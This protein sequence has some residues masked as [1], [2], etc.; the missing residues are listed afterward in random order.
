MILIP[1]PASNEISSYMR[2]K[3][4]KTWIIIQVKP[5]AS[6]SCLETGISIVCLFVCFIFSTTEQNACPP[7]WLN[8]GESCFRIHI[9]SYET[10]KDAMFECHN[11]GGRLA[12]L[13][14]T[15]KLHALSR[16]IDEYMGALEYFFV[17]AYTTERWITVRKQLFPA[18]SLLWGPSE[19]SGDGWCTEMKFGEKWNLYWKGWRINDKD[20][21]S[22]EGFVCEK[23]K[24]TSGTD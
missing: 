1:L 21:S 12:V 16:F 4:K 14:N 5:E 18:Q 10:W 9:E 7:G 19:P 22:K 24:N 23:P 20:C 13:G 15:V 17:G 11:R 2:L 3:M 8:L 6:L